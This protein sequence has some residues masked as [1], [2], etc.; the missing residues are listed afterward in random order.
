[1]CLFLFGWALLEENPRQ[2]SG[3]RS[4]RE[5]YEE[6]TSWT[7]N[8]SVSRVPIH[9]IPT[10]FT[11]HLKTGDTP[12]HY[13]E[14]RTRL[15]SLE[16]IT[17]IHLQQ[18][19]VDFDSLLSFIIITSKHLSEPHFFPAL[20][21]VTKHWLQQSTMVSGSEAFLDLGAMLSKNNGSLLRS[22]KGG[23]NSRKCELLFLRKEVKQRWCVNGWYPSLERSEAI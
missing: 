20:R 6:I 17:P 19:R 16:Q 18:L 15:S 13:K 7:S 22:K 9:K 2:E 1:M 3:S 10:I 4:R 14:L 21:G 11:N 5:R 12:I 23:K 8:V